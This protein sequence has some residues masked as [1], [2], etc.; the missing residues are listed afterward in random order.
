MT[1]MIFVFICAICILCNYIGIPES[2]FHDL[3]HS[4]A[5]AALSSGDDAKTVQENLGHHT[6]AFPL[7]IYGHVS[8]KMKKKAQQEWMLI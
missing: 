4:Y 3:R 7:D 6:A 8:E 5:A 2:R 1:I